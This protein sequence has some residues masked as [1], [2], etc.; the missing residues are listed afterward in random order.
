[1]VKHYC[2][3]SGWSYQ[4]WKGNFYPQ[5]LSQAKWFAHYSRQFNSV[6]VNATFYRWF[7]EKTYENWRKKA[8]DGFKY[9]I[10]LPRTITHQKLLKNIGQPA[11]RFELLAGHLQDKLGMLLMQL[12]PKMPY[13]PDR[14]NE[15]LGAFK[16][17]E[18]LVVEF[19]TTRFFTDE[20]SSIL[21]HHGATFCIVDS[22]DIKPLPALTSK[23][24]YIRMHGYTEWYKH[25][26]SSEHLLRLAELCRELEDKGAETIYIFFNN[27]I[28]G[29]APYNA[30]SFNDLLQ[31]R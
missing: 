3:T 4:D 5:K 25:R 14:L 10:K 12:P 29:H 7:E 17:P 16:H 18:K 30:R 8:P 24:A 13:L 9:V 19:R 26:Y 1:M 27:N 22:P 31:Q 2:G 21:S 6:E 20:I 23:I 11:Q 15:A 28:G